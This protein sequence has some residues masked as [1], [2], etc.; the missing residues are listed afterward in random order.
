VFYFYFSDFTDSAKV[1]TELRPHDFGE[2]I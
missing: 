2:K 1:F